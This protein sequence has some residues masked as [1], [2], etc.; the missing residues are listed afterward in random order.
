MKEGD[1]TPVL[2]PMAMTFD[3]L[4][5]WVA[6]KIG[7]T[8]K[9]WK[10]LGRRNQNNE[11]TTDESLIKQKRENSTPL[12]DLDPN[13]LEQKRRKGKGKQS[14]VAKN[15]QKVGGVAEAAK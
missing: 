11:P 10:R 2:G 14:E 15:E 8:T 1:P 4:M 3:P 12:S 6:E 13:M 5:G 9:H 7:P